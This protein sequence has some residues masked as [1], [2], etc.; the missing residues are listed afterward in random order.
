MKFQPDE[1]C[2]LV[3]EGNRWLQSSKKVLEKLFR[4]LNDLMFSLFLSQMLF[5]SLYAVLQCSDISSACHEVSR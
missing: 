4:H 2:N 5:Y 3:L 1:K